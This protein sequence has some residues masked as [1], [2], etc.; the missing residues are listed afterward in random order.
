MTA[1]VTRPLLTPDAATV[2]IDRA[3]WRL[4]ELILEESAGQHVRITFCDGRLELMSPQSEY[5]KWKKVIGGVIEAIAVERGL[6]IAPMGSVT[7]RRKDL[8]RGLEADEC[9]YVGAGE[10]VWRKK[11]IDLR[12][13]PPP[14]LVVEIDITHHALDREEIYA[15]LGVPEVWRFDGKRVE[16]LRLAG[17]AYAAGRV[18]GAFPFLRAA[19][20]AR[21]LK[22]TAKDYTQGV[23]A[24]RDWAREQ[25]GE[26]KG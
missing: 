26:A 3:S 4:Y 18:S 19:A 6:S 10:R 5:E 9:Y 16:M 14:D 8:H 11:R 7:L 1:A 17:G 13:D 21:F 24:V 15:R 25:T 12:R 20:L 23:R 2:L 22:A